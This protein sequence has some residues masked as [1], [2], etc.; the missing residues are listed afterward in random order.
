MTEVGEVCQNFVFLGVFGR[1]T[2]GVALLW[3]LNLGGV[4]AAS[5]NIVMRRVSSLKWDSWRRWGRWPFI[6]V[7]R[8]PAAE[9][10][11]SAGVA[12]GFERYLCLWKT[13]AD[14][15]VSRV[16]IIQIFHAW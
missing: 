8:F 10:M 16:F 9:M 2:W 14:T 6:A 1:Q 5:E 15:R 7:M 3:Y 11:A 4:A 13:V 12:V